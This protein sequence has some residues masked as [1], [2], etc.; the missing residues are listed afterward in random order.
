MAM[1][2]GSKYTFRDVHARHWEQLA[3][4]VGLAK[5]QAK[6][7]VME[8]AMLLPKHARTVQSMMDQRFSGNELIERIIGLIEQRCSLTLHR[9]TSSTD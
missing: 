4:G 1:K 7:R 9:L 5:A 6:K 8:L 3:E 2:I